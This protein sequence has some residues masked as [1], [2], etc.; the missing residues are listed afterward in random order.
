MPF[1]LSVLKNIPMFAFSESS[2]QNHKYTNNCLFFTSLKVIPMQIFQIFYIKNMHVYQIGL[3]TSSHD[4]TDVTLNNK[5]NKIRGWF[6][7]FKISRVITPTLP[8]TPP[9]SI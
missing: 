6:P 1:N 4:I 7:C 2:K 9:L 8:H 5:N 3:K